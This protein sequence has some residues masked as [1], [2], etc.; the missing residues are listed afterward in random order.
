[1]K[2]EEKFM[3]TLGDFVINHYRKIFI[4]SI[5]FIIISIVLSMNIKLKTQMKDML[6]N[7]NPAIQMFE[8]IDEYFSGATSIFLLIHGDNKNQM[9]VCAND[10]YNRIKSD[11]ILT[12]YMR[13]INL[14]IDNEFF[15]KWGMLLEDTSALRKTTDLFNEY[16]ILS[17][18][19]N[20]NKLFEDTYISDDAEEELD[21]RKQENEA[22][23]MLNRMEDYYSYLYEVLKSDSINYKESG[24]KL[25]EM[26][27][28]GNDY[29]FNYN[30]SYLYITI[31]PDISMLELK[32]ITIFMKE[33]KKIIN[34]YQNKYS[35][36]EIGYTGDIPVQD[37]EQNAMSAD[38]LYPAIVALIIIFILFLFSFS[39]FRTIAFIFISLIIGIIFNYGF[40]GITIKEINMLTSFMSVLLIGLGI[41]YGIQIATNF[42]TYRRLG[43]SK[44]EAL[45]NT[46]IKSGMGTLLAA[47]TTAVAFFVMAI[48]GSKAFSQFGLVAGSG[49]I[50]CF[51]S[52]ILILPVFLLWF[53][54]KSVKTSFLPSINYSFLTKSG[55]FSFNHK[56]TI[57]IITII[58]TGIM[59]F[60][61]FQNRFLYD[62]M[63]ME[64]QSET[65]IK[66]YFKMMDAYDITPF[67]AMLIT[68][69]VDESRDIVKKLENIPYVRDVS[70]ISDLIPSTK[71]QENRIALIKK[72][73]KQI[74]PVK[75]IV[76]NEKSMEVFENELQNLEWNIIELGDL[77]VAGLGENNKILLKRNSMIR[78]IQGSRTIKEGNEIFQKLIKLIKSD[79][80]KYA[81]RLTKLDKYF[82]IKLYNELQT[83][84]SID[85]ELTLKD[86]PDNYKNQFTDKEGKRF[87]VSVFPTK[88]VISDIKLTEK[89]SKNLTKV[90]DKFSGSL[91]FMIEWTKE[92]VSK[93]KLAAI[94]I[95]ITVFIFLL[96]TFR[97]FIS[98]FI[99]IVPLIIGMIWMFGIY[100]VLGLKVNAINIAVIP[101]I[102]GMGIDFGIH[103]V[104]RYLME[105]NIETVYNFTGKAIFLSA[106][107]TMIGFG[108]LAI[109]G[110][111]K[112]ISSIGEILF[113]GISCVLIATL[114]ILPAI[115]AIFKKQ[116]EEK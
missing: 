9:I 12:Q 25:A 50:F 6:P 86:I 101:L 112:A 68:Y 7:D 72:L 80:E 79:G 47:L 30:N 92:V 91:Q 77:S 2:F 89:F 96:I 105:K 24:E 85:K 67:S 34:E 18:T 51:L 10:I 116:K 27:I 56:Y 32:K 20:T 14:K 17:I 37:A 13:S 58:I 60:T 75:H 35:Q 76:Y 55:K 102:I 11:T 107:T 103:I 22:L 52:M 106:M 78:E 98:S 63:Q 81:N 44:E 53:S 70:S 33:F 1:M 69:S 28:Y 110:K 41:D 8:E 74:K 97:S 16:N 29:A 43:L 21:S 23:M 64:P 108:S 113:V 87:L 90:S 93:S 4:I 39:K 100:P 82:S 40:I 54:G 26:Y 61:S 31:S 19:Q 111:Y 71:E 115:L 73:R 36:L 99:S 84:M 48:T 46:Y 38:M 65:A 3:K 49:I 88:D 94:Y 57:F 66:Y 42:T 114:F 45:R 15:K 59:I 109:I 62:Y 95:L 83:M 104:H 5:F